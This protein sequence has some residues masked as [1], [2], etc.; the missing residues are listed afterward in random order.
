MSWETVKQT[1]VHTKATLAPCALALSARR[2][3]AVRLWCTIS[4]ELRAALGW[5]LG[6]ALQ[7][8][9]GRGSDA[10]QIRIMPAAEGRLLRTLP[11]SAFSAV[12]LVAPD[13]LAQWQALRTAA[14]HSV[15]V[16]MRRKGT[17]DPVG[18]LVTLPWALPVGEDGLFAAPA[19]PEAED[20]AAALEEAA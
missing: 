10:G 11:R 13:D 8:Q 4:P 15:M 12:E 14:E 19:A 1:K 5:P 6:Q 18:L 16:G 17:D 20:E 9:V 7:L 3:S 2:N